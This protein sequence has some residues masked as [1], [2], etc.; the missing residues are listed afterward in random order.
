MCG[1]LDPRKADI[2]R[3]LQGIGLA[4]VRQLALQYPN[5][6]LN[7]GPF[8]IYLGARDQSRGQK[9]VDDLKSDKQLLSAKALQQDGGLTEIKYASLDIGDKKS[10]QEF[11]DFL[12]KEHGQIDILVNNAGVAI[13]GF[14]ASY[15]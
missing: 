8:L 11:A 2:H 15:S 7:N 6:K 13:D 9:A 14:G 10:I 1:D 12:K 5:S 4:I 3:H